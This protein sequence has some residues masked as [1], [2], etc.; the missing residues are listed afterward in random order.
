MISSKTLSKPLFALG[1]IFAVHWGHAAN[2]EVEG[3][4]A[5][6]TFALAKM[7]AVYFTLQN[8]TDIDIAITGLSLPEN[9]ANKAELHETYMENDMAKM[10]QLEMPFVVK[11]HSSIEFIPRGK[12]LMIMGLK[13]PLVEGSSFELTLELDSGESQIVSIPVQEKAKAKEDDHSH[14]HHH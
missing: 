12:H 1:L 8:K 6:P 2:L 4:W 7:G 11:S 13:E 14:H 10:R 5:K 3:A 9:V